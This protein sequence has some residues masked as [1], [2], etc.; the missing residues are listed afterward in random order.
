[1]NDNR[2]SHVD[3]PTL[4]RMKLACEKV[5]PYLKNTNSETNIKNCIE[6]IQKEQKKRETK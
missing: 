4:E 1:M 2:L 3:E 6:T 5:L